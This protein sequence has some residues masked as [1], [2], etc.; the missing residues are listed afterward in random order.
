MNIKA[1]FLNRFFCY[2][3]GGVVLNIVANNVG[4]AAVVAEINATTAN[5][6]INIPVATTT[7]FS[8]L[9]YQKIAIIQPRHEETVQYDSG[10]VEV[11]VSIN[12][13]LQEG[14]KL[15][16]CL[17][18]KE[19]AEYVMTMPAEKTAVS[20]SNTLILQGVERGEH[21]LLAQIINAAIKEENFKICNA[22]AH[23]SDLA[24][25]ITEEQLNEILAE[26]MEIIFFM[27]QSSQYNQ[28]G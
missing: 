9:P 15:V 1:G 8:A 20:T 24:T 16:L 22:V 26:S 11:K 6:N 13:P 5:G 21:H 7:L 25:D 12:P 27:R 2:F 14:H 17:D 18:E 23:A 3:F 4:F 28:A 19:V 10:K